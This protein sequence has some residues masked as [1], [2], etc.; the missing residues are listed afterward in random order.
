MSTTPTPRLWTTLRRS[1]LSRR[2]LLGASARA[3]VGVAGLALV[4]CSDDDPIEQP[5]QTEQPQQAQPQ[6]QAEPEQGQQSQV[7]Q[8]QSRQQSDSDQ[9]QQDQAQQ[10]APSAGPQ[11][12]GII[13][14]WLPVERHDRWDPHRS[15]F[16]YTQAMHSLMYNRLLRP[17][18]VTTGQLEADLCE[19][20]EMPDQTTYLFSVRPDAVFWNLDP[21]NGRAVS[22]DDV[23]WNISRQQ[24]ALDA[25]DLPDP[26]FFR[27]DAYQRS[28]SAEASGDGVVTLTSAEPDASYLGSV[29]A[30][31]YAWITSPEAAELYGDEWRDDPTDVMRNSGTG[32]YTPRLYNGFE[33]TLARSDNWWQPD[34]ALAD[35]VT[36]SSGDPNGIASLYGSAAFDRA[37]F[38]LTNDA[39]ESLREQFP[40]HPTFELPLSSSVEL[41][42]PISSDPESPLADPRITR[43][44]GL[45]IDRTQLADR[46]FDGHGRPTGPLPWFFE[47][48]S[49]T[50]EQLL[51]FPGF[52][53]DRTADLEEVAS[54]VNAAGG[55]EL[56]P[57]PFVVADLFEGYF[58]G[59]GEAVRAMIA[60]AT[61]FE[62]DLE[63]RPFADSIDQL[64]DG[65]RF[66][67][68][69][70]SAVPEQADPT[71]TWRQRLHSAG[72]Q[73]W[74]DH[75][76]V[77][78]D[79]LID[80]MRTT[81]D[82]TTRQGLAHQ[83]QERL[84][85]GDSPQWQ[86]RLVH[87]MQFGIHQPYFHPDPRVFEFAWSTDQLSHSWIDTTHESYPQ[88]RAIPPREED[89]ASEPDG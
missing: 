76:D 36:F 38:P 65:E 21:T 24:E 69:G 33:L 4:G 7:A 83:V 52:R 53:Q 66:C 67:L 81:F 9:A 64:R 31:P 25:A 61:G 57:I 56:G 13:R 68:L 58:A 14:A 60:D 20:P 50:E 18:S 17:T 62:V 12:G 22:A 39:V 6:P 59:V 11:P 26:H 75:T 77:E 35:G 86:W 45:S 82:L 79:D 8:T 44:I 29:H 74:S 85:N 55:A 47:G 42:L 72:D 87:G 84:L 54:L 37:D 48:W 40:E 71:D 34:S 5:Q 2:A 30:S 41:L 28:T 46:L 32:P 27:S 80:Q 49:L 89:E 88:D 23:V 51:T 78:L 1:R 16:R 63:N 15:R 43:A 3:G 10:S 70:W 73:R 19:L